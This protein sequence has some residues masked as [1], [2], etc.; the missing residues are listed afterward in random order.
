MR[1]ILIAVYVLF[2]CLC[3]GQSIEGEAAP[4]KY[5]ENMVV[6]EEQQKERKKSKKQSNLECGTTY[7]I[8]VA[9]FVTNA[10]FG[11]VNIIPPTGSDPIQYRNDGFGYE[12]FKKIADNQNIKIKNVGY[13]SY[14]EAMQDLRMGKID[15]IVGSYFDQRV[16]GSGVNL[17][18]PSYFSNPIVPVFL[19]GKEKPI[20]SWEDLR[21]LKGV[22]RQ[23]ENIYSLIF[24]Q[25]PK[26]LQIEQVSGAKKAFTK[27]LTGEADYMLTSLYSG[28]AEVRR[29][30]LLKEIYFPNKAIL[31]PEL[32]FVFSSH[33][34][35]RFLKKQLEPELRK[36]KENEAEY[37][38]MLITHIDNWG[39]RFKD[40]PG[41]KEMLQAEKENKDNIIKT[42]EIKIASDNA[43]STVSENVSEK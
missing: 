29:Y 23:E 4:K 41:L 27:L 20:S 9:G 5:K 14:K 18:F 24:N 11:W 40:E 38:K 22:V 3:F 13:T 39:M 1:K 25:L 28:E 31:V 37:K 21:G 12:I 35:C 2:I 33:S 42:G 32:F 16:L 8:K 6:E 34:D 30:K 15:V 36:L 19:K 26:D 10:P 43:D 7:P 17:M